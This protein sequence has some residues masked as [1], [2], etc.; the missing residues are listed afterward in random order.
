[1][2]RKL[3]HFFMFSL[4]NQL[5][6]FV[7]SDIVNLLGSAPGAALQLHYRALRYESIRCNTGQKIRR[8]Q[9]LLEAN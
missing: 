5:P 9:R 4:N 6:M 7:C 3:K 2:T 1:M 8:V